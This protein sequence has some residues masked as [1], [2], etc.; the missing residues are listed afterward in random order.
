MLKTLAVTIIYPSAANLR[1]FRSTPWL[2]CAVHLCVPFRSFHGTSMTLRGHRGWERF[3]S[4]RII[5]VSLTCQYQMCTLI[6][7]CV[8][9]RPLHPSTGQVLGTA[10]AGNSNL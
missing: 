8:D 4:S 3:P 6:V 9:A 5:T 7:V 2:H 1:I 10:L